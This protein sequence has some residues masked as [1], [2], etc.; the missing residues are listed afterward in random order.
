MRSIALIL[1]L[2]SSVQARAPAPSSPMLTEEL[3]VGTWVSRFTTNENVYDGWTVFYND[4]TCVTYC[5]DRRYNER[6]ELRNGK[7]H[8]WYG[9]TE[10]D[11]ELNTRNGITLI[12]RTANHHYV[13]RRDHK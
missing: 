1:L 7:V 13:L 8:M 6:W 4:L 5:P 2:C 11:L 10:Y 12:S 3:V 9:N